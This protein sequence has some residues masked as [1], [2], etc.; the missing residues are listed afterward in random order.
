MNIKV[1]I[2]IIFGFG[3][4]CGL[5]RGLEKGEIGQNYYE[6]YQLNSMFSASKEIPIL[7]TQHT[8]NINTPN[9]RERRRLLPQTPQL[10]LHILQPLDKPA[11]FL[12]NLPLDLLSGRRKTL[13]DFPNKLAL[14]DRLILCLEFF[15][16]PAVL[17]V[18]GHGW[19]GFGFGVFAGGPGVVG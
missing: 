18:E 13:H 15:F 2:F 10:F 12:L 17:R 16:E 5:R 1:F 6:K 14:L 9:L 8:P 11:P 4:D 3:Y 19:G 7:R